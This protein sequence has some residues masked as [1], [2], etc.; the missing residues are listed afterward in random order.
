MMKNNCWILLWALVLMTA[1]NLMAQNLLVNGTFD[2]DINGWSNPFVTSTWVS[3]DG[4]SISGNGSMEVIGTNNNNASFPMISNAFMVQEGYWYSL[5]A[6]YKVPIPS[7]VPRAWMTIFWYDDMGIQISDSQDVSGPFGFPN[8]VWLDFGGF[9][10]APENAV[11][12]E[13]RVFFQ[14]GSGSDAELP[15]GLWDD[16]SVNEETVFINGFD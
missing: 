3:D 2:S 7:P 4:A 12:G 5:E 15:F 13:L 14:S 11:M 10:Q 9:I 1:E 8:D 6:S 16:I